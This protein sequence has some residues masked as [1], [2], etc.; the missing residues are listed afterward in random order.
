MNWT[1]PELKKRGKAT[2]KGNY[3]KSV[4]VAL[5]MAV[6]AGGIG[7]I[8]GNFNPTA[9]KKSVFS[10][11][12]VT[13]DSTEKPDAIEIMEET[14][15][16]EDY[17]EIYAIAEE[18]ISSPEFKTLLAIFIGIF[19]FSLL[20]AFAIS[21]FLVAPLMIGCMRF[22]KQA[23]ESREYSLGNI[24]YSFSKSYL[25]IVK[26]YLLMEVKVFLWT[27]LL[28]IP[29]IIKSYEYAMIP[30]IL[31]DDPDISSK[32]AFKRTK[33]MM[34]G[35]KWHVF[36][37]N[38]SFI[39]WIF[40]TMITLGLVG[41][42]YAYPYIYAT[43]AELYL[44]LRNLTYGNRVYDQVNNTSANNTFNNGSYNNGSYNAPVQEEGQSYDPGTDQST[45]TAPTAPLT[46][47]NAGN[48]TNSDNDTP[49]FG[50]ERNR[51]DDKD[52]PFNIPY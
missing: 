22:F 24:G 38:L 4:V 31:T 17:D 10:E 29:G 11:N 18:L 8:S 43:E 44:T 1:I 49:A 9:F 5:V 48:Y 52:K 7:G 13:P 21:I 15:L 37:L 39:G 23:A 46:P 35:N 42:F 50:D 45:G 36:L 51:M 34:T 32:D 41:I 19:V 28:I 25:N 30:Y 47:D 27:L 2:F 3:W 14:G 6:V 20:F 40:L 33:E 16:I 12:I 26:I